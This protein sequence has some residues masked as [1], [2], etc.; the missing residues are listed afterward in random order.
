MPF[1][2]LTLLTLTLALT[3]CDSGGGDDD[4]LTISGSASISGTADV[5]NSEVQACFVDRTFDEELCNFGSAN[6]KEI[7]LDET[8]SSAPYRI[9]GLAAGKYEMNASKDFGGDGW[10]DFVAFN[11]N[12]ND[13]NCAYWEPPVDGVDIAMQ[14][15]EN[16]FR[17]RITAPDGVE[18]TGTEVVFCAVEGDVCDENESSPRIRTTYPW[19]PGEDYGSQ[20]FNIPLRDYALL[21]GKDVNG[22]GEWE[23]WNCYTVDGQVCEEVPPGTL[24][25]Y[26][27]HMLESDIPP[28]ALRSTES[29]LARSVERL[30]QSQKGSTS[31]AGLPPAE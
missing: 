24:I 12:C 3:A 17:L 25:V 9:T 2:P 5:V 27:I 22:D 20:H 29:P 1:A 6:T 23:F 21:A 4:G 14:E 11:G 31:W 16:D 7:N 8:G 13:G 30:P 10:W 28:P 18:L 15:V 26:T 19:A